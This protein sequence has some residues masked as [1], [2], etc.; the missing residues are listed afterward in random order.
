[1]H[2]IIEVLKSKPKKMLR[3]TA[4]IPSFLN[5][6]TNRTQNNDSIDKNSTSRPQNSLMKAIFGQN[7]IP[8]NQTTRILRKAKSSKAFNLTTLRK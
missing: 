1:M 5:S 4:S 2:N 7:T 3:K 8:I 6:T